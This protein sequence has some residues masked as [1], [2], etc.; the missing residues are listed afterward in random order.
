MQITYMGASSLRD[1][2]GDYHTWQAAVREYDF[3]VTVRRTGDEKQSAE[4]V[5]R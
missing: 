3:P 5:N 2:R 4:T 1:A